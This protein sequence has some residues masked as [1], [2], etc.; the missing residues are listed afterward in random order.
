MFVATLALLLSLAPQFGLA[1]IE[2]AASTTT[3]S[4]A[5]ATH[6]INVGAEGL[7]FTPDSVTAAV[8]DIICGF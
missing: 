8:G 2:R 1:Q 4:A 6:S 7:K 5:A 3:S